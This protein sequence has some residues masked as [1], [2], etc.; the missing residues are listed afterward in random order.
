MPE[1]EIP[2]RLRSP[3]RGIRLTMLA[4]VYTSYNTATTVWAFVAAIMIVLAVG[5]FIRGRR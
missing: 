5:W 4:L 3:S 2:V 1:V